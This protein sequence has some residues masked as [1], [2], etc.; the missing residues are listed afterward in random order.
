[1]I[2][3]FSPLKKEKI[4][5][6]KYKINYIYIFVEM[7]SIRFDVDKRNLFKHE[8]FKATGESKKGRNIR[9]KIKA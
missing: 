9:L 4:D 5:E 7:I 8:K 6:F 3:F 2:T 1:M